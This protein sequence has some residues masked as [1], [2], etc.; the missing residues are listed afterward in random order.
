MDENR[1][2]NELELLN[3]TDYINDMFHIWYDGHYATINGY[4]LGTLP[5][6]L[7]WLE[8]SLLFFRSIY[9]SQVPWDEIN[10]AWG[11]ATLLLITIAANLDF[12]FSRFLHQ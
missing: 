6:V 2:N 1:A 8:P 3:R 5:S 7:V 9:F 11:H 12:K 10:A 4:R